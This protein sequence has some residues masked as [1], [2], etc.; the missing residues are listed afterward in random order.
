MDSITEKL[1]EL[2]Y[3]AF[4]Q[5]EARSGQDVLRYALV[6]DKNNHGAVYGY[7]G[8]GVFDEDFVVDGKLMEAS[9]DEEGEPLTEYEELLEE[10]SV[11]TGQVDIKYEEMNNLIYSF[12]EYDDSGFIKLSEDSLALF[13][14]HSE[15]VTFGEVEPVSFANTYW[16]EK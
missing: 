5:K 10:W 1:E 8:G 15:A 4:I 12:G 9:C 6:L 14:G 16:D 2:G 7:A 13:D 11:R 3:R